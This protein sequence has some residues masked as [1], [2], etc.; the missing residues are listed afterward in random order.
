MIICIYIYIYIYLFIYA[1]MRTEQ[2]SRE[3]AST[4][5]PYPGAPRICLGLRVFGLRILGFRVP[6][7]WSSEH[8]RQCVLRAL[9]WIK[10]R[11]INKLK[12][13]KWIIKKQL[14][15]N[16]INRTCA[17]SELRRPDPVHI[18]YTMWKPTAAFPRATEHCERD[19]DQETISFRK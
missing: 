3:V 2:S 9:T 10:L 1:H 13:F 11:N 16:K 4:Q 5:P 8:S 18:D 6:P 19:P 14:K 15:I 7:P 12:M 17:Y